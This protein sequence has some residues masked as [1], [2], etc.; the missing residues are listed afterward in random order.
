ML[1]PSEAEEKAQELLAYHRAEMRSLD[2]VYRYWSGRQPAPLMPRDTPRDVKRLAQQARNNIIKL[3]VEVMVQALFVEGYRADPENSDEDAPG[4]EIWQANRMDA[5]QTG[6][7]R[8][9]IMFGTSY[10]IVLPGDPVPVIRGKSPRSLV[11]VYDEDG[12]DW[13]YYA[14]EVK[15]SPWRRQ[16]EYLLYDSDSEITL[17]PRDTSIRSSTPRF[18]SSRRH[19]V[20]VCP[21]VRFRNMDTLNE[22]PLPPPAGWPYCPAP[23][24]GEVEDLLPLQ[25]QIN[26]TTFNLAVAEQFQA[27][28]QRY[29][30]GW[31][32][33]SEKEKAMANASRLWTF[34]D[35]DT[36]AGEFGQVDLSGYL[37][38]RESAIAQAGAMSQTPNHELLGNLVN[39]SADALVA[40]QQGQSRKRMLREKL[41]GESHEQELR[42]ASE[43]AGVEVS[44]SA[45]VRWADTEARSF[46][47]MIDGLGKLA[48]ML[49]VPKEELW[50]RVPGFT[51]QDVARWKRAAARG[52]SLTALME[53]LDRQAGENAPEPVVV[54]AA[55]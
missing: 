55:A 12:G 3:V 35:P 40:A 24:G 52:D 23:T 14:L 29:I 17:V 45:Q 50:E 11:A 44:D 48:E 7:H 25:D 21:V 20:G 49:D 13:P 26:N 10:S 4:W 9:A 22:P 2:L 18:V 5:H 42:L 1:S 53:L 8:G 47:A 32:A 43:I 31:T 38:S 34:E 51:Q 54:P 19:D 15:Q 6:I 30:M 28:K 36:K 33:D 46:A 39:M 41:L 37:N 27:F 16:A